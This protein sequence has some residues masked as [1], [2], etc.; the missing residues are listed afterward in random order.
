MT[1]A[2]DLVLRP[3]AN[4][5]K[6]GAIGFGLLHSAAYARTI[7]VTGAGDAT[8]LCTLREAITVANLDDVGAT[9]CI[10]SGTGN[11]DTIEFSGELLLGGTVAL[12]VSELSIESGSNLT[13]DASSSSG[14]T[15]VAAPNSRVLDV[16]LNASLTL[17]NTTI[18]GANT[19]VNGGGIYLRE[20]ASLN[21][22]KTT[23]SNNT[24]TKYGGG[25]FSNSSQTVY[26][27]ESE[28]VGNQ[29]TKGGGG[30][31]S[32]GDTIVI[33]SL[34]ENNVTTEGNG[35]GI[36]ADHDESGAGLVII[37]SV[38]SNNTAAQS[39]GGVYASQSKY[40]LLGESSVSGN[41]SGISLTPSNANGGGIN[42]TAPANASAVMYDSTI[43]NNLA[44]PTGS[45]KYSRG[46][47]IY[48][49]G[50]PSASYGGINLELAAATITGNTASGGG[51][52]AAKYALVYTKYDPRFDSRV[53]ISN[54]HSASDEFQTAP[55]HGGGVAFYGSSAFVISGANVEVNNNR[56]DGHGGGLYFS[57][58][59][60]F[61]SFG[62][63]GTPNPR[64][65]TSDISQNS[66]ALSGGGIHLGKYTAGD[67]ATPIGNYFKYS[68][69]DSNQSGF[70]GGGMY[71]GEM[72]RG[73]LI[74]STISNNTSG[75]YSGAKYTA[76][77]GGIAIAP[78][79]ALA[80]ENTTV[81]G[82]LAGG[83]GGGGIFSAGD[84]TI[85]L[86]SSTIVDNSAIFQGQVSL[87]GAVLSGGSLTIRN[88]I[89]ANSIAV[90]DCLDVGIVSDVD[91]FSIIENDANCRAGGEIHPSRE[92]DPD[93]EP[94]RHNGGPTKTH[95]PNQNSVAI[96][97][98]NSESCF[99]EDQ[100]DEPRPDTE[101]DLCDVGA[102]EFKNSDI[103]GFYVIPL[104]NGK[105]A[106]VPE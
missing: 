54:N 34:V 17:K 62:N 8:V 30:V 18:T 105:M 51:G 58:A 55:S 68:S 76:E 40:I 79:S 94:L 61:V 97:T 78:G 12:S 57:F 21:L 75:K 6:I 91:A 11:N 73:N 31:F 71:F 9:G 5:L 98:G 93:L 45:N 7:T 49:S 95:L 36:C 14:I 103:K 63:G 82:N 43:S 44:G 27:G 22:N 80:L 88:S 29:A 10:A 13:I 26:F 1:Q 89:L 35:G 72:N 70:A 106:V 74:K 38:V 25:I 50:D 15:V 3:V 16:K 42:W 77:G 102:V 53:V 47:G 85:D 69:I 65:N 28:I 56:A 4:A 60:R 90:M 59:S 46:G 86:G 32:K 83:Y 2:K 41:S 67:P 24:T 81:S 92:R 23:V 84:S 33:E 52:L 96:N 104:P 101:G 64:L 87:G 48:L 99:S 100:R 66:A 19:T 39:G 37:E 20:G